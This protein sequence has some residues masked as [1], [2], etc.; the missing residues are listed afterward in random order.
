M[1]AVVKAAKVGADRVFLVPLGGDLRA[2]RV[3]ALPQ[4]A[5]RLLR[6]VSGV[7]R[8]SPSSAAGARLPALGLEPATPAPPPRLR[9]RPRWVLTF[10]GER[11]LPSHSLST[12]RTRMWTSIVRKAVSGTVDRLQ[13]EGEERVRLKEKGGGGGSG[14]GGGKPETSGLV[15]GY[16]NLDSSSPA[17][18]GQ[19][20]QQVHLFTLSL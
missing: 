7:F 5:A 20:A 2:V 17:A 9:L 18:L 4:A 1:C 14:G 3:L 6:R 13:K 11:G 16:P 10:P 15:S 19:E 12:S 8:G